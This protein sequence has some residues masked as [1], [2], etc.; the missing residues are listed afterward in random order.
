MR[1]IRPFQVLARHFFLR[2]FQNDFVAFEDQMK[3]KTISVL[4]IVAVLSA[5]IA[6]AVL[7]KYIFVA[8]EGV[9]WVE[10]CYFTSFLM[11]LLGFITVVEWEVI[12]PDSRDFANLMTLPVRLRTIFLTKFTSLCLFVG[13]FAL[14]ANAISTFAFWFHLIRWQPEK[15]FLFTLYFILVHLVCMLAASFFVFFF[16]VFVIGILMVIFSERL[17]GTLSLAI[18]TV[19]MIGFVFL[20]IY[21]MSDS[22]TASQPFL[23]LH[24]LKT[25][26][27][28]LFYLFPPMWFTGLY[29]SLLGRGDPQFGLHSLIALASLV[30]VTLGFFLTTV[31]VYR[32]HCRTSETK[33]KENL[34]FL[35]LTHRFQ[36][37]FDAVFLR[38][39]LQRGIFYFF[40]K[41]LRHSMVHKMRLATFAAVGIGLELILIASSTRNLDAL[42]ELNK[43]LLTIPMI[44]ILF[45]LVGM[46]SVVNIP[47]FLEANWVF[48]LTGEKRLDHYA[49]GFRKGIVFYVLFPLFVLVF[50]FFSLLW[51]WKI[52]ALHCLYGFILAA[53]IMEALFLKFHKIPFTCSYFP[54]KAKVH[55]FWFFY[56]AAFALYVSLVS[57]LELA[58]LKKTSLF[59]LFV[60][61]SA[62]VFLVLKAYQ[63]LHL[64][65]KMVLVFEEEPEPALVTL[66]TYGHK[67]E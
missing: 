12:F 38:N 40:G 43:T 63:S 30:F 15:G 14:G 41:T 31:L 60:G 1:F 50:F 62:V 9:S 45:L 46:R 11:L 39:P 34:Q 26:H 36:L 24:S 32:K 44:L 29:E 52:G 55:L 61:V 22:L 53:L 67:T 16:T 3:E 4:A 47:S 27:S 56:L 17:F 13:L 10:K 18:R 2:L 42:S 48:Q 28:L 8:D 49:A 64:Y 7:M 65:K 58:L 23:F 54:G 19:L 37:V 5:H 51:G 59:I 35:K 33:K 66:M 20:M 21:I 25:N 57:T 6:N